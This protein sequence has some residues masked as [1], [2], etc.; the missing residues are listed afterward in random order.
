MQ[1]FFLCINLFHLGTVI[2]MYLLRKTV[3]IKRDEAIGAVIFE[4]YSDLQLT[5]DDE[6]V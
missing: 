4:F 3:P 6:S 1:A 2:V 5:N